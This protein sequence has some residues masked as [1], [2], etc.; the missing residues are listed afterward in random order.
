[1]NK[2]NCNHN[3]VSPNQSPVIFTIIPYSLQGII[4]PNKHAE[5]KFLN[6]HKNKTLKPTISIFSTTTNTYN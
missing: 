5:C 6:E 4:L 3:K 1:M 2:P